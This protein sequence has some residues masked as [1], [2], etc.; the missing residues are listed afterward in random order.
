[1][2]RVLTERLT[3]DQA[4]AVVETAER[5]DGG[6]DLY[7]KGIFIQ[8]GV[9]NQNERIYPIKEIGKAVESINEKLQQGHSVLGEADHP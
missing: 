4:R 9:K 3:F 6:K 5:Q 8:G 1:M 7:M 2:V